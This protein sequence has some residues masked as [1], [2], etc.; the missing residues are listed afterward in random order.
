MRERERERDYK[1]L[2]QI[3][4]DAEKSQ[5]LQLSSW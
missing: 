1:E 3:I 2:F 5:D 4:I